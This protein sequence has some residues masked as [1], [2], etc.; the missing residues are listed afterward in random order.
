MRLTIDR[1]GHLGDGIGQGPDGA[2][3][4]VPRALPGEVV[5]GEAAGGRI[6]HPVI[7]TPSTDRRRAPCPHYAAC[8]GC[9]LMHAT[10]AFVAGWKAGVVAAA[11]AGQGLEAPVQPADTSP[12]RSRRRATLAGRRTKKGAIVGFHGRA[13]GTLAEVRDCALLLPAL[14]AALPL[15]ARI[16]EAGAS[17]KAELALTVTETEGGIDLAASGGKELDAALFTALAGLAGE[18]DLARLTWNGEVVVARRPALQRFGRAP[19]ASPPG[20]FLQATREGEAALLAE[21]R[22]ALGPARRIA[23]LFSGAGTFALP[24][25]EGAEVHAAEAD[26][27]M[28]AAL[29][30]AAR[31]APGLHPVSGEAR[32]LFRRP[33][34]PGELDRFDAV[35]LDPPRAGAEAQVQELARSR[36]PVVAYVSCNPTTF[37]RDARILTGAGY[38]LERV[39]PVDQFR[40]SAHVELAARFRRP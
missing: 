18:G 7:V 2:P 15:L 10:D 11:L 31:A 37:A 22:A 30:A 34:L 26:P 9:A 25:A 35:I 27:A 5:E 6:E 19:V 4:Y 14:N 29:I 33:L 23:D 24:L 1:L 3:V 20:A 12:E 36:V 40:W 39:L 32:D 28:I 38:R 8:G 21:V 17:R 13:S 16:T